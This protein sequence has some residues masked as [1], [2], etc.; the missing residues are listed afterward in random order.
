MPVIAVYK[1]QIAG[2]WKR[3]HHRAGWQIDE[4]YTFSQSEVQDRAHPRRA[5]GGFEAESVVIHKWLMRLYRK[6]WHICAVFGAKR[7]C[8]RRPAAVRANLEKSATRGAGVHVQRSNFGI[9]GNT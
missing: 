6:N 4:P 9:A 8:N 1:H 7:Q 2:I 5:R 3:P